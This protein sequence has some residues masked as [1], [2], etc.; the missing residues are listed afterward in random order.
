MKITTKEQYEKIIQSNEVTEGKE[1]VI[2]DF[3]TTWCGPC[4]GQAKI[5]KEGAKILTKLFPTLKIYSLDCELNAGLNEIA[6]KLKI[7]SIPQLIVY[8]GG[9]EKMRPGTKDL[10]AIV[11]FLNIVIDENKNKEAIKEFLGRK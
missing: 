5:L 9:I 1:H 4:K 6:D 8:N 10:H 11:K 7:L 3:Y 2:I